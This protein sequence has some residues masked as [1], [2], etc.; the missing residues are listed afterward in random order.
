MKITTTNVGR[1]EETKRKM[2]KNSLVS[3][4]QKWFSRKDKFH[5]SYRKDKNKD[6]EQIQVDWLWK[7][8]KEK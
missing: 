7:N 1:L 6:S 3:M 8:K 5:E 2:E 4:K